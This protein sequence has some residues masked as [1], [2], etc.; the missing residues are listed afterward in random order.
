M[1]VRTPK[2]HEKCL[3]CGQKNRI[4]LNLKFSVNDAEQVVALVDTAECH[5]GYKGILHG[6]FVASLLDC[7]MCHALFS[8]GVEAVTGDMKISFHKEIPACSALEVSGWVTDDRGPL[9]KTEAAISIGGERYASGSA[10]F[11]RRKSAVE[12]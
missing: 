12:E 10:R 9:Y 1:V 4:G 5:Q 3:L 2:S 11:V 8:I 6:G 7:A